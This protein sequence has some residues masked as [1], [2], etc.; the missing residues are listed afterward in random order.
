MQSKACNSASIV[1]QVLR[2]ERIPER[3]SHVLTVLQPTRHSNMLS[4]KRVVDSVTDAQYFFLVKLHEDARDPEHSTTFDIE[5]ADG[6]NAWS[7]V[8]RPF[9]ILHCVYTHRT[10]LS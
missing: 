9:A 3:S 8:G 6:S 4:C 2:T 7:Q 1:N 5:I 10:I